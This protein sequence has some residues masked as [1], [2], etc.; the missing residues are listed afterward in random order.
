ME[1]HYTDSIDTSEKT[2]EFQVS[3]L[4]SQKTNADEEELGN[5]TRLMKYVGTVS[6]MK[7]KTAGN[8]ERIWGGDG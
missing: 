8:S 5:V 2:R 7:W 4:T 3:T 1:A 6:R